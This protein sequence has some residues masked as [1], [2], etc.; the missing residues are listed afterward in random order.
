MVRRT[1]LA[2]VVV[3]VALLAPGSGALA[4]GSDS[5]STSAYLRANYQLVKVAHENLSKSVSGY[6][7]VLSHVRSAC[8]RAAVNSPQD[9]ESTQLSNEVIGTMVLSAG[10]PD[11]A[12]IRTFLRAVSGLHWSSSPVTH[13][14]KS[15]TGMLG[16]LYKLTV[17]NLCGDVAAWAAGG[18]RALPASTVSF[19]R[20][21][22]PD[23]VALGLV[24]KGI[25]RSE[26][27][28]SRQLAQRAGRFENQL[29]NAEA[30][31]VETW[32]SIMNTLELNP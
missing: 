23:W 32:G 9:P 17:P 10:K 30:E 15:Y 14:V 12:A 5:A 4:A 3:L 21:F 27:A 22:Y 29:T 8:P 26:N 18:Y 13:A 31:A 24:P 7:S 16:Q 1:I 25:A 6:H 28:E 19:D 2:G 11:L 20:V